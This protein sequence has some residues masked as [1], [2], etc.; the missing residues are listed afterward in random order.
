MQSY[1]SL[2]SINTTHRQNLEKKI[3]DIDK[4]IPDTSGLVAEAGLNTKISGVENKLPDT[5]SLVQ[6]FL[7]QKLVKL[8]IRFQIMLNI[9]L[10]KNLTS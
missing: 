4:K 2:K 9:L 6:L 1:D 3:G 5:S 7:I 8:R 10:L